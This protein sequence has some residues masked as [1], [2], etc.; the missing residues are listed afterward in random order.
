MNLVLPPDLAGMIQRK[1]DSGSYPSP[2]DVVRAALRSLQELE[3]QQQKLEALRKD[4]AIGIE[5]AD[6]GE[7]APFDAWET[8]KR[9]RARRSQAAEG[10]A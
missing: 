6:R 8:L 9:V 4:V 10:G 2:T 1:V 7:L 5:Q 3:E